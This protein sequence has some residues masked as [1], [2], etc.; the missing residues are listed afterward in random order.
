MIAWQILFLCSS[1]IPNKL[2]VKKILSLLTLAK[3]L[4]PFQVQNSLRHA[5][6]GLLHAIMQLADLVAWFIL[7]LPSHKFCVWQ[8]NFYKCIFNK[9]TCKNNTFTAIIHNC[10][11]FSI[12]WQY[13]FNGKRWFVLGQ[14]VSKTGPISD[15]SVWHTV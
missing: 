10:A 7:M 3:K 15:L 1:C 11:F 6:F 8:G 9:F 2:C 12:S 4:Q 13:Y 14:A 5:F